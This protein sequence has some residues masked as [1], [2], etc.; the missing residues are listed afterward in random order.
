MLG[1][2]EGANSLETSAAFEDQVAIRLATKRL[3]R[4]G[5]KLV[6]RK[7][8]VAMKPTGQWTFPKL[9]WYVA[10]AQITPATSS[11]VSRAPSRSMLRASM[12]VIM[13]VCTNSGMMSITRMPSLCHSMFNASVSP[14]MANLVVEYV[15]KE[16]WP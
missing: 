1:R 10:A 11:A 14:R 5:P 3:R 9:P 13:P 7:S 15:A 16:A 8:Q 2:F 4:S 12:P 6:N